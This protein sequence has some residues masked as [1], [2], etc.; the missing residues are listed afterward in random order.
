MSLAAGGAEAS[1]S[2]TYVGLVM[3]VAGAFLEAVGF[4]GA[5]PWRNRSKS[6]EELD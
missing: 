3:I 5:G 4:L 2:T 6:D 1:V